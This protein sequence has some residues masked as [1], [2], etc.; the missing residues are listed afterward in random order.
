M[1]TSVFKTLVKN[2]IKENF[3]ITFMR[4]KKSYQNIFFFIKIFLTEFLIST[5]K[6]LINMIIYFKP[7][8]YFKAG[9]ER[10]D[11]STPRGIGF[12]F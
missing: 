5:L 8:L 2:P 3:N 1:L 12:S 11:E 7:T 10:R 6:T 9:I 4:N